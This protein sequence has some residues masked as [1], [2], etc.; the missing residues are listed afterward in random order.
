MIAQVCF[1]VWPAN[2]ALLGYWAVMTQ[3]VAG[4]FS[5][6]IVA[7]PLRKEHP[8]TWEG[9]TTG[10][11][12]WEK[13]ESKSCLSHP[14]SPGLSRRVWAILTSAGIFIVRVWGNEA[15]Q[16][17]VAVTSCVTYH[18]PLKQNGLQ[19]SSSSQPSHR[20]L[21]KWSLSLILELYPVKLII[22]RN[23]LKPK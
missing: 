5:M 17:W 8:E 16:W 22:T 14:L 21:S 1:I 6:T 23:I 7:E 12:K 20:W 10:I 19:P 3:K 13:P 4:N 2:W 15:R 11:T 18:P 9:Y